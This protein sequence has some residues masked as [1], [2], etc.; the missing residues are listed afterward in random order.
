M[1]FYIHVPTSILKM[2]F[3]LK[4]FETSKK[5]VIDYVFENKSTAKKK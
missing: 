2:P 5:K 1:Q 4:F 3:M